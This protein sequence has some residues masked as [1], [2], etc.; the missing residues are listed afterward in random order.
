MMTIIRSSYVELWNFKI[1][2]HLLIPRTLGIYLTT[3]THSKQIP[4]ATRLLLGSK[5]RQMTI[6]QPFG[7]LDDVTLG[8]RL[9]NEL[10]SSEPLS[11]YLFMMND[12]NLNTLKEACTRASLP[13]TLLSREN[14]C[15]AQST[16][17]D[18]CAENSQ[19]LHWLKR[20]CQ[21]GKIIG[22]FKSLN[23]GF[24]RCS[25]FVTQNSQKLRCTPG[26]TSFVTKPG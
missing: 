11:F 14:Q 7:S 23:V 1:D 17:I 20:K 25:R 18:C 21:Q 22:T 3:L 13:C 8:Y 5:M 19:A 9:Q 26:S 16:Q 10:K 6:F 4:A 12:S 2:T 24:H 15:D